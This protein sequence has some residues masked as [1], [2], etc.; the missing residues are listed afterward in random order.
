[1]N[2]LSIILQVTTDLISTAEAEEIKLSLWQLAKEG[3]WIMVV[4]AIFSVIAVYI[5]SE[6]FI[7]LP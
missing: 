3:G 7:A 4:L 1:M 6:R 2:L 5:F